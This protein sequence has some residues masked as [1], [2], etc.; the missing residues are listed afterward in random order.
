MWTYRPTPQPHRNDL[1]RAGAITASVPFRTAPFTGLSP[2]CFG[3]SV[4][5][6][7]R[8]V[9]DELRRGRPSFLATLGTA[10]S[11]VLVSGREKVEHR[12]QEAQCRPMEA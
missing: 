3:K 8:E 10:R 9:P 4:T 2:R 7:R 12:P 1:A 5:L 11:T 6:L